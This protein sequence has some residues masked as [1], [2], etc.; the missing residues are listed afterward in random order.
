MLR[1]KLLFPYLYS[2]LFCLRYLPLRQAVYI[3]ILIHP[4]VRIKLPRCSIKFKGKLKHAMFIFGFKG[5]TGTS[6]CQSLIDI[7]PGGTLL[8][9]DGVSMARGTRI[10]IGAKGTMTIG[11]HFW[12]NGDCFFH[13]TKNITIGDDNMYGWNISFNTSDG[14]HVYEDGIQKPM[15]NDIVISNHVWIAS[16][17]IISKNTF[18]S[19]NCVVA[20]HSLLSK[21]YETPNSLIAG[22]PANILKK[23]YSWTGI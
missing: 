8:V 3:P 10:I 12:C 18:V 22:I 17:C 9:N 19:D 21:R 15:E 7:S 2:F 23:N 16:H 6:N 20:Q 14:H 5:T 1:L 4:S 13:C 11:R